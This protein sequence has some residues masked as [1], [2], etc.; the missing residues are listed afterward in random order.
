VTAGTPRLQLE[1]FIAKYS[2]EVAKDGRVALA[3]LRRLVPGAVQL[4]YDNYNFLVVGFGPSERAS[5]AV[6]SLVFAPRWVSVCF[7]QDGPKLPDPDGLLRGSGSQVRNVRLE[8]AK[9]L[10][11]PAVKALIKT[12]LG[13]ARV[14]IDRKATG[15]LIIKSISA[16]QRPRRPK[17][18]A[19]ARAVRSGV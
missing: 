18:G 19:A 2:P 10:D 13:R 16:K 1:G 11:K 17:Q 3:K 6:L 12:A 4:V 15:S 5:E 7:L 14:P 8:S 9:D